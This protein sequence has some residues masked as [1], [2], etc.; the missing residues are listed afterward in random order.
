MTEV[1]Q[2]RGH[3]DDAYD[4]DDSAEQDA[5]DD[6]V[7]DDYRPEGG[8]RRRKKPLR[9]VP[10]CLA[11]LV[12]LAILFGG[13]YFVATRGVELLKDQLASP[14]DYAGPG[15]GKVTFQVEAGDTVAQMG[16]NLK[17][18]GVVKSVDA[19][20]AAALNE[21]KA[22]GIQVGYYQL[23]KEMPAADALAILVD[24]ANILKNTVTIPEGFTVNQILDR[25]AGNTDFSREQYLKVLQ[26]PASIGLPDYAVL[27]D[28]GLPEGYLFPSTYDFGPND[29][30]K[31]ILSK[32]VDRWQQAADE[33]GLEEAAAE[34]GYTPHELM[35]VAS[36]VEAEAFPD[37]MPN[38]ARVI[39]NR[40]DVPNDSD[41]NGLLQID[42][43]VN[44]GLDQKLGV[45]ITDEQ[46]AIDT[47]YNTYLNPGLPPTP[48]EAPGDA[49]IEAAAHPADGDW[50][51]YVTVNLRTGE[52]KFAETYDEFLG[53]RAEYEEYCQ[54]SDAC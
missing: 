28:E 42:A 17:A 33:A 34:L 54:T 15:R 38:V 19:F 32:M 31:A 40:L 53:Y 18:Q 21:P 13:L 22:N 45:V 44:Y 1:G 20:T 25:L 41:T 8:R 52:T 4:Y 3:D 35:V 10:G 47:P 27:T 6:G 37:D 43:A 48:I 26:N 2:G 23:Q 36:L 50:Y 51:F 39:Y 16:R 24:P 46:K 7:L 14:G 12:A 29:G 30:P 9:S 11:A 49:A 5:V